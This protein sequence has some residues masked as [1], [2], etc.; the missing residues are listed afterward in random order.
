MDRFTYRPRNRRPRNRRPRNFAA[1]DIESEI[2][3]VVDDPT[4]GGQLH[5][6]AGKHCGWLREEKLFVI[7]YRALV[8]YLHEHNFTS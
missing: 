5:W 7:S 8:L 4:L 3:P 1:A 6:T 2:L